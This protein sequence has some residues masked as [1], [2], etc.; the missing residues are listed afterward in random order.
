MLHARTRALSVR[1]QTTSVLLTNKVAL[2]SIS[3]V[4]PDSTWLLN[5]EDSLEAEPSGTIC[6]IK[7]EC[8]FVSHH[9]PESSNW[10]ENGIH[11]EKKKSPGEI[12]GSKS[13]SNTLWATLGPAFGI[14]FC[15]HVPFNT[16]AV[17]NSLIK[18]VSNLPRE[19]GVGEKYD[20]SH[21]QTS[22]PNML[23]LQKISLQR[24]CLQ[25]QP[26][27]A[28]LSGAESDTDTFMLWTWWLLIVGHAA[29]FWLLPRLY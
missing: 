23:M 21:K 6:F 15:L 10:C 3:Q 19:L 9:M 12:C 25:E 1:V 14:Y 4:S 29:R 22:A 28:K 27:K 18:L 16:S 26:E 8:L 20:H 7:L 11:S 5:L 13:L 24:S 17:I 2:R